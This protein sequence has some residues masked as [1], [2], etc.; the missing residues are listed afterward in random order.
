MYKP[1][2]KKKLPLRE[3]IASLR[4]SLGLADPNVT[5]AAGEKKRDFFERTAAFWAVRATERFEAE[6]EAEGSG[7][8]AGE[9]KSAK[10]L[11]QLGYQ[12]ASERYLELEPTLGRLNELEEQQKKA[13]EEA[14]AKKA[15]KKKKSSRQQ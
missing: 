14:E 12:L 6:R 5:P 11:R 7:A 9:R 8:T 3:E 2:R 15:K 4:E 13:E 1:V 10:E